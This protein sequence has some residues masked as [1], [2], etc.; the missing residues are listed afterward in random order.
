MFGRRPGKFQKHCAMCG[1]EFKWYRTWRHH[2][3][4]CFAVVC[5][6]CSEINVRLPQA[7][8]PLDFDEHEVCKSGDPWV[9][10]EMGDETLAAAVRTYDEAAELGYQSSYHGAA[11]PVRMATVT[12]AVESHGDRLVADAF[13]VGISS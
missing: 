11:D 7:V 6:R 8:R 13:S 12:E 3:G 10:A 4:N 2:C 5:D 1:A 9:T